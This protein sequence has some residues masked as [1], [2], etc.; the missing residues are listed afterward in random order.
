MNI[1]KHLL[2]ALAAT[3]SLSLV[4]CGG[5]EPPT[6]IDTEGALSGSSLDTSGLTPLS[7]VG[8]DTETSTPAPEEEYTEEYTEEEVIDDV[9]EGE[10]TAAETPAETPDPALAPDLDN[11]L[12]PYTPEGGNLGGGGSDYAA[13]GNF[14]IDR[15]TFNQWQGVSIATDG[16]SLFVTAVDSKMPAKGTVIQMNAADGEG[17]KDMGKGIVSTITLGALGYTMPKTVQGIALDD[18]TGNLVVNDIKDQMFLFASPKYSAEAK[19][20][21]FGDALDI[22]ATGG[23]IFLATATG[24]QKFDGGLTAGTAFGTITPSGGLGTDSSGNLYVVSGSSVH[25][26]DSSGNATEMVKDLSSPID[27]AV[28]GEGNVFVLESDGVKYFDKT[29]ASKGQ[30]GVGEIIAPKSI[31][32]DSMG[33][34]YVADFGNDHKDSQIMKFS[35]GGFSTAS[36]RRIS[37]MN[38]P[39]VN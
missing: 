26:L 4:G 36:F 6:G 3:F 28:D 33:A 1:R 30:F 32:A 14:K 7:P 10:E 2:I 5:D 39:D 17:W 9:V 35:K 11:V 37:T 25:K 22:A 19:K 13:E 27:V 24:L 31:A 29:G 18:L 23:N 12:P 16:S 20:T 34:V 15:D 21:A 8:G 38:A